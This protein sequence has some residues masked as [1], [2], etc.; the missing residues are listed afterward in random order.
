MK[1]SVLM[2]SCGCGASRTDRSLVDELALGIAVP[3]SLVVAADQV[4][5]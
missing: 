5:E 3:Q 2:W 1:S 4:I